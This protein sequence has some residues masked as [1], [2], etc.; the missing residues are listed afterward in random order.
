MPL[1]LVD[2]DTGKIDW[3]NIS[4]VGMNYYEKQELLDAVTQEMLQMR[5][6]YA[7]VTGRY[8]QLKAEIQILREVKL[9]LQSSLKSGSL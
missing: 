4:V 6:E 8:Q 1:Q 7:Q 3:N 5:V 9:A 2:V